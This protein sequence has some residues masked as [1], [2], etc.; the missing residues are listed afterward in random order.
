MYKG[1][2]RIFHQVET[3]GNDQWQKGPGSEL[4][5][6]LV[7][8]GLSSGENGIWNDGELSPNMAG[9]QEEDF[10][11][12]EEARRNGSKGRESATRKTAPV[13]QAFSPDV[14]RATGRSPLWNGNGR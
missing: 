2:S 4:V 9:R 14:L 11:S 5:G 12:F 1:K 13:D 3:P 8:K 6:D 7:S 10:F